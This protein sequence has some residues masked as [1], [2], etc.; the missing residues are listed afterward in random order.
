LGAIVGVG[1]VDHTTPN[2]YI[3]TYNI[4]DAHSNPAVQVSRT[5]DVVDTTGPLITPP[6]PIS[7][8]ANALGGI[9]LT[10][11]AI[12][13]WL[14]T[15]TSVDAVEGVIAVIGN[16]LGALIPV[17]VHVVQFDSSDSVPNPG[18]SVFATLTITDTTAP[19]FSVP[20]LPSDPTLLQANALGGYDGTTPGPAAFIP[21]TATD[22]V[23]GP[24][25]VVC[26]PNGT[27]SAATF[28]YNVGD[29]T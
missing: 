15:A 3:I 24:V 2:S 7:I 12:V 10:D 19:V 25:V 13:T 6:A 1:A 28:I 27:A 21:P 5:V 8:E 4:V 26:T 29:L 11:P 22:L 20:S 23:D 18:A 17:G 9:A 16:N 14:G